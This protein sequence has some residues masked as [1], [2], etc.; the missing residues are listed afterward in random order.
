MQDVN[1][2]PTAEKNV[3]LTKGNSTIYASL[4]RGEFRRYGKNGYKLCDGEFQQ[5]GG[6]PETRHGSYGEMAVL[7]HEYIGRKCVDGYVVEVL[8]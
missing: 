4:R 1:S 2:I 5:L 8:K 7:F 6:A 3:R